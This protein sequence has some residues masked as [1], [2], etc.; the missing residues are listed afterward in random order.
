MAY[1][2]MKRI[3]AIMP[4][5]CDGCYK[6]VTKTS[7]SK[8]INCIACNAAI[9]PSCYSGK[10]CVCS[11][12]KSWVIERYNPPVEYVKKNFLKKQPKEKEKSKTMEEMM[13]ETE[14]G[15]TQRN[16]PPA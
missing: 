4:R 8:E 6:I 7:V 3:F 15:F 16:F 1:L 9:C 11:A 13:N 10:S 2:I 12:C 5:K 14:T